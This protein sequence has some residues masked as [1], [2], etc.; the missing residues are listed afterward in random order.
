MGH[1]TYAFGRNDQGD[2]MIPQMTDDDRRL[3]KLIEETRTMNQIEVSYHVKNL[4]K[5]TQEVAH[6]RVM[7]LIQR[8]CS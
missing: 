6:R 2:K 7:E 8:V 5:E 3:L 1:K 4:P